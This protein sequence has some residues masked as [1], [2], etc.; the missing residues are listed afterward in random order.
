[1]TPTLTTSSL[2][3]GGPG[4]FN[5]P[6]ESGKKHTGVDIVANQSSQD[7]EIYKVRAVSDGVVAYARLNGTEDTNYG[8][9]VIID[10]QNGFYTQYS[11]LAI[12]ASQKL[13]K[14][15]DK[16]KEGQTIG[17]LADLANNEKSSGNVRA[18]VV[19][20]YDKIQLHFEVFQAEKGRSSSGAIAPIKKDYVL[21]DP[22]SRFVELGYKSF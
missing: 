1:M 8:Y 16:V 15:G 17:Y 9:T 10:H 4:K 11:H 2:L 21:N 3:R 22:S 18:D 14:L 20:P 19:K 6:R 12:N 7:K 5:A 13:V